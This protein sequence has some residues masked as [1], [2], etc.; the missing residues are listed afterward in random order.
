MRHPISALAILLLALPVSAQMQSASS[1]T[2]S[3]PSAPSPR[4]QV[5]LP[6]PKHDEPIVSTTVGFTYLQT[7]LTNVNGGKAGYLMGWYGIPQLNLTKHIGVL[8]DF[9]NFYNWHAH[10]G[11]NVHG[12]TGGP[13]YMFPMKHMTPFVFAEGGAVRDSMQG[14]VNWSPAVV[15]GAGLNY[16]LTRALAFQL[17]PGEYVATHLSNGNWQS[18]FNAKAGIVLNMYGNR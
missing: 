6:N 12:F 17:V 11:E 15:G 13:V 4:Q 2:Q 16:K 5:T 14:T 7:D 1:S 10:A 3:M 18:N 9:T 8:A